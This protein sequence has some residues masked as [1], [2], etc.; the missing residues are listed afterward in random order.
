MQVVYNKSNNL[1]QKRNRT[2]RIVILILVLV[3]STT[4]GILH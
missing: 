1:A 3:F 2:L 4:L